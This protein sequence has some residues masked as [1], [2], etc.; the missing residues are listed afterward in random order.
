M[1]GAEIISSDKA[2]TGIECLDYILKG[3]LFKSRLY[4][5]QGNLVTGKTMT[6]LQFLL[7]GERKG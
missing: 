6:G 4:L 1:S 2:S 5:V 7:E 3:E